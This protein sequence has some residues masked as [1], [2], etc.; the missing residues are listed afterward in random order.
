[1]NTVHIIIY[2]LFRARLKRAS[3]LVVLLLKAKAEDGDKVGF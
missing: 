2:T 3:H 1:M